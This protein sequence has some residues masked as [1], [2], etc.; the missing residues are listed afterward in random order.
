MVTFNTIDFNVDK[1]EKL[2]RIKL[3]TEYDYRIYGLKEDDDN[4]L[5]LIEYNFELFNGEIGNHHKQILFKFFE[6]NGIQ[7]GF[8]DIKLEKDKKFWIGLRYD[9]RKD[10]TISANIIQTIIYF[11][12]GK[13]DL[14]HNQIVP[15]I[16]KIY[17]RGKK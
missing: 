13:L 11:L 3:K 14:K 15:G 5:I 12:E 10:V 9:L 6:I 4:P 8:K 16:P 17:K 1:I 2:A 7:I